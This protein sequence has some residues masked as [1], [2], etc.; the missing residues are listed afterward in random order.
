M[1]KRIGKDRKR[2]TGRLGGG[3]GKD[4]VN[5]KSDRRG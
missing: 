3:R 4:K 1:R 2:E 5:G